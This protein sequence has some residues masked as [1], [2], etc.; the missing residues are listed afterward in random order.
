[1]TSIC[2]F[3]RRLIRLKQSFLIPETVVFSPAFKVSGIDRKPMK[4]GSKQQQDEGSRGDFEQIP[5]CLCLRYWQSRDLF[6]GSSYIKPIQ[7]KYISGRDSGSRHL[8]P[9]R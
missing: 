3:I 1:M 2:T 6:H 9:A 4:N 7:N 5:T 8:Q